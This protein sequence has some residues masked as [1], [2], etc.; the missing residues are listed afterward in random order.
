MNRSD[1]RFVEIIYFTL[2]NIGLCME[3]LE[4]YEDARLMFEEQVEISKLLGK[5]LK[6]RANSLLNLVNLHLTGRVAQKRSDELVDYLTELFHVSFLLFINF[7]I[8][9]HSF[10]FCR[11][12]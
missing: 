12:G 5:S 1:E 3:R 2:S 10:F 11:F 7:K 4:R 8:V 6:F 9:S